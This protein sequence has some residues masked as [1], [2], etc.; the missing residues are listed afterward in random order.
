MSVIDKL[1]A[2]LS[3]ANEAQI[4]K[5]AAA[6][7]SEQVKWSACHPVNDL[8]GVSSVVDDFL[9]P[10]IQAMPDLERKPFIH[11]PGDYQGEQ[12]IAGTGYL[13]GTFSAPLFGIPATGKTLY[14]RY[15]ELVRVE[16]DRITQCYLFPDFLDAMQQAGVYPLR[17]SLGHSGLMMPPTS[18]DGICGADSNPDRSMGTAQLI[19]D[20]LDCLRKYDGKT[21][22]S[23]DL[24]NFW[25]P[26]FMWYG[27]AGIGTTRG[28]EGFRR[29][30]QGPFLKG[31]P[32]RDVD[33]HACTVAC[34]DYV[35]TGGWPHMHGTHTGGD[36]LGLPPSN[37]HLSL[38][39]MD[40]W[41]R[42]GDLLKE[43][44]VA[45]DI[46]HMLD[47]MGLD[48]FAQMRAITNR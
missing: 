30:H 7:L 11:I 46:P 10:M 9:L 38:R 42:E 41:R 36:W 17:S 24:E 34:G 48:V 12:W 28:I 31:F 20:M 4:R 29:Q 43:N 45:I 3:G 14:L 18:L 35:A 21:L 26:D 1:Y 22:D 25:H 15:S 44:W 33:H 13:I 27:P 6:T 23:M 8:A 2:A 32:D 16:N 19:M 37:R 40:I 47:Q 5:V 39:V